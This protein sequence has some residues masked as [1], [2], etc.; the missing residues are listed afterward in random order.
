M[1]AISKQAAGFKFGK[2]RLRALRVH[3]QVV[4]NSREYRVLD[5]ETHDGFRYVSIRLYNAQGKFIKQL[6]MEPSVAAEL[7]TILESVPAPLPHVYVS[8][9]GGA[10]PCSKCGQPMMSEIHTS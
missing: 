6:L 7:A 1:Q 2:F 9:P 3:G 5:V 10:D 4:H 8:Q